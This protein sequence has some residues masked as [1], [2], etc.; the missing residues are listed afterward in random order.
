MCGPA[1]P[2]STRLK[3]LSGGPL[4]RLSTPRLAFLVSDCKGLS[5][6]A[7]IAPANSSFDGAFVAAHRGPAIL[8][9]ELDPT[10]FERRPDFST[11]SPPARLT[12]SS[13]QPTLPN[14]R[15]TAVRSSPSALG[16]ISC[17][18]SE[19]ER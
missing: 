11:V 19:G 3:D 15:S 14:L 5:T 2:E 10:P 4:G 8:V 13:L 18:R 16:A 7:Q 12:F 17:A 6:E 1:L 9:D